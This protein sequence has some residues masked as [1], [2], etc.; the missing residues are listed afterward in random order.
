MATM[1]QRSPQEWEC[2]QLRLLQ[3]EA[4]RNQL[5]LKEGEHIRCKENSVCK[6][7]QIEQNTYRMNQEEA[8]VVNVVGSR[9]KRSLG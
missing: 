3:V 7:P 1:L 6:A 2:V 8:R 5:N 9:G 4:S